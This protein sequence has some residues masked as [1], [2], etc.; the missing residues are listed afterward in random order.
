MKISFP[1]L[2]VEPLKDLNEIFP[3]EKKGKERQ[4]FV[5]GGGAGVSDAGGSA[6][7]GWSLGA[8]CSAGF[9]SSLGAA[10]AGGF[11]SIV[12]VGVSRL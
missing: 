11:A 1:R 4:V 5:A 3:C 7:L 12:L 9:V 6:C 10:G 2:L 8:A